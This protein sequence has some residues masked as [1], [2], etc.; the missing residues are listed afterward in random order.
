ML[1]RCSLP[2]HTE[3][4]TSNCVVCVKGCGW[5]TVC[6]QS[7]SVCRARVRVRV[8]QGCRCLRVVCGSGCASGDVDG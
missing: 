2:Q 6:S 3:R 1:I 8:R 7:D 5:L 4:Q